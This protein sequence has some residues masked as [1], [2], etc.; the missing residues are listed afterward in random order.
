L[1]LFKQKRILFWGEASK[2]MHFTTIPDTA[3]YTAHAALDP[4]TP[5]YLRVAGD[6]RSPA[7]IKEIMSSLTGNK[8]RLFRAGSKTFLT[9]IIKISKTLAPG[10]KEL[11]PAFQ[12][13]Q[14]MRNMIDDRSNLNARDTN[15]YGMQWV[16][17]S[18]LIKTH[19]STLPSK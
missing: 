5:R 11:Y 17:I 14:Y 18:D 4:T 2:R 19:V 6:Q 12:G 15:R 7:Q 10:K 13:M 16:T 1:I 8:F 9:L 3:E